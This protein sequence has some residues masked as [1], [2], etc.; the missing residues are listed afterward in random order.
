MVL[1]GIWVPSSEVRQI[2]IDIRQIKER[3]GLSPSLEI[4]W[5]K[6]SPAKI[7]FYE[8]LVDYFFNNENLHFR[9]LVVT[10]KHGLRH[11]DFEQSHDSWYYKMYFIMLKAILNP[12]DLYEIYIDIKDTRSEEKVVNLHEILCNNMY[13]FKKDI[14]QRVQQ[15]R[16]HEVEILQ[17]TDLLIGAIGYANRG[18]TKSSAKSTL[19]SKIRECSNYDLTRSTLLLENKLNVFIW[20]PQEVEQ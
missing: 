5:T 18:L 9:S 4:K 7:K 19:V 8:H 16:S 14:I 1:G 11:G 20:H 15:I 3:H 2:N 17:L 12:E 10:N 13:D 6:I